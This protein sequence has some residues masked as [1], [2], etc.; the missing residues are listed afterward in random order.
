MLKYVSD[1]K[2]CLTPSFISSALPGITHRFVLVLECET[3]LNTNQKVELPQFVIGG[4][5]ATI[6]PRLAKIDEL[7]PLSKH[8]LE[9]P[10]GWEKVHQYMY[11]LQPSTDEHGWQYRSQWSDGPVNEGDEPW[12][13]SNRKGLDSRRRLWI[14]TVVKQEDLLLAKRKLSD[15]F[16]SQLRGIIILGDLYRQEQKTFRKVWQKR[17]CVLNDNQIEIYTAAGGK[18]I[19]IINLADCN[20]KMLFGDQCPGRE[21]SFALRDNAGNLVGLFDAES[22]DSRRRWVVAIRYQLAIHHAAVNFPPFDYGPPTGDD[23]TTRVLMCGE[24]KKQGQSVKDWKKR[25]F[26]LTPV[27]LQYFDKEVRRN[28]SHTFYFF[29]YRL[30]YLYLYRLYVDFEWRSGISACDG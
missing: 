27:S 11:V 4:P 22:R 13:K 17:F 28:L 14:T 5:R 15:A 24:L 7:L 26:Q 12:V 2:S 16:K 19:R 18:R 3:R 10:N 21:F 20:I 1:N 23:L 29:V 9:L 30:I 25:F 8:K 6:D